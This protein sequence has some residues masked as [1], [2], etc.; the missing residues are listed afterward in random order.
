MNDARI[1]RAKQVAIML[2]LSARR[3]RELWA[4]GVLPYRSSRFGYRYMLPADVEAWHASN[5]HEESGVRCAVC[6]GK[7]QQPDSD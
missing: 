7:R 6:G 5:A 3:V 4:L 2:G 1:L